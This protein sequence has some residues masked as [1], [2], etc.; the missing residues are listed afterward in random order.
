VLL[1]IVFTGGESPPPF[2]IR[3]ELDGN[4]AF[5]A[6]ADSGLI[7]AEGAGI[8]PDYITG[9]MDSID[10]VSRLEAYPPR[11]VM[12]CDHDKDYTD[13]ELALAKVIEKGCR[14]IWIIGGGGGRIDHLFA[15]RSLFEREVFPSRWITGDS[16]IR[17]ID[18]EADKEL[19]TALDAG[20]RVSVFPLGEGQWEAKSN[21]LKWPLDNVRWNRGFSAI[22]NETV[23]GTFS[24]TVLKGRFLIILPLCH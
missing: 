15:I 8:K 20:A 12:R 21:G 19:S 24:V 18:A 13:T 11:C 17:C 1:G 16:D 10:D 14:R 2:V 23:D 4:D 22:S 6:A 9:D 3:K 5:I 7:A